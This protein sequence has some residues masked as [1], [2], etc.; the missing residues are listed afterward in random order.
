MDYEV[1]D[2]ITVKVRDNYEKEMEAY[3]AMEDHVSEH[4]EISSPT[5]PAI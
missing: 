3:W 5:N 1:G 2:K 4:E